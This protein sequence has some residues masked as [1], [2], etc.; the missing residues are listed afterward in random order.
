[1]EKSVSQVP[2]LWEVAERSVDLHAGHPAPGTLR[3][4]E[5]TLFER[6][7]IRDGLPI[8]LLDLKRTA[9]H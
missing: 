7:F 4:P 9:F 1:M 8:H 5:V 6:L 3:I 2:E